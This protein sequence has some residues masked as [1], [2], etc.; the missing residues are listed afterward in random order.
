MKPS[1]EI[2]SQYLQ[3]NPRTGLLRWIKA[4]A[5]NK[6]QYVGKA[7]GATDSNGYIVI[8][9]FGKKYY[10]HIIA[11]VLKKKEWPTDHLDHEDGV[12]S[13]NKWTNLRI[14]GYAKNAQN[15]G[16]RPGSKLGLKGVIYVNDRY[17]KNPYAAK[18][19]VDGKVIYLGYHPTPEKAHAVYCA[20]AKKY[21][22]EFARTA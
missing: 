15:R 10:A 20:A 18:I 19:T 6:F 21:H 12:P 1:H 8:K 9:I 2:L 7:A 14:A 17:R 3:Y 5:F 4:P 13:N 22:K 11:W 16:P